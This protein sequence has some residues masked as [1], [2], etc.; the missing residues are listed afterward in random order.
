[1]PGLVML[2]DMLSDFGTLEVGRNLEVGTMVHL[3]DFHIFL[4]AL[5]HL[6]IIARCIKDGLLLLFLLPLPGCQLL[7]ACLLLCFLCV[8]PGEH[9]ELVSSM[10]SLSAERHCSLLNAEVRAACVRHGGTFRG[11]V[12]D[13]LF[14]IQRSVHKQHGAVVNIPS[15]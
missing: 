5:W 13:S 9:S 1:M 4:L 6:I 3:P 7:Q 11:W 2:H 8:R 12:Y 15:V 10:I 14:Y